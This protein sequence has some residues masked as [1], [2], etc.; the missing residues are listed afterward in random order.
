MVHLEVTTAI[1]GYKQ[2]ES[3]SLGLDIGESNK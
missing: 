2:T 1:H 3:L